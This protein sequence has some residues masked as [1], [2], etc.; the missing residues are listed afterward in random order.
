MNH[1]T[2]R[3]IWIARRSS[4][5]SVIVVALLIVSAA[6]LPATTLGPVDGEGLAAT[7]L[8]R[9]KIGEPAPDF[10]LET[11]TGTS[12]TLS[13]FRGQKPVILVFYRGHW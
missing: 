5:W 4:F 9:I 7:D 10:T 3:S 8:E 1:L 6:I 11:E 2:E 13:Q 12:V